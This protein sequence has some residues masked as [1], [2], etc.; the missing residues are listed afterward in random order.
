MKPSKGLTA[1]SRGLCGAFLCIAFLIQM[2]AFQNDVKKTTCE[3]SQ[4]VEREFTMLGPVGLM[5]RSKCD[6]KN[7]NRA[8]KPGSSLRILQRSVAVAV[9]TRIQDEHFLIKAV[10]AAYFILPHDIT[11]DRKVFYALVFRL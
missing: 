3:K 11:N 9:S 5:R 10:T 4:V 7:E 1:T 8:V 6:K 2:G